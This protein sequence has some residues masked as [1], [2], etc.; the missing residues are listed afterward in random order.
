MNTQ[1]RDTLNEKKKQLQEE[2]S[3]FA[4][5][6]PNLKGDWDSVYPR[7]PGG[8]IED[9]ANE[10]RDYESTL[11]TEFSLEIQLRDV[12]LALEKLEKG[13]YGICESCEQAIDKERLEAK[14]EARLCS[15]CRAKEEN[16]G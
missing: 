4:K 1:T 16:N 2:L 8:N 15:V 10:V 12:T 5:K 3:S 14:P 7:V 6:D 13:T 9:A 11:S